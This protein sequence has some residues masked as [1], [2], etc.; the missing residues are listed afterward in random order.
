MA[1]LHVAQREEYEDVLQYNLGNGNHA[2]GE[3]AQRSSPMR[4]PCR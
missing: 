1:Y 4:Q 3:A 2:V